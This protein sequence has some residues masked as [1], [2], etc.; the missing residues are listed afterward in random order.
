MDSTSSMVCTQLGG[1]VSEC[2]EEKEKEVW[3]SPDSP[4]AME[5]GNEDGGFHRRFGWTDAHIDT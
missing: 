2:P 4:G 1:A 3:D 5:V